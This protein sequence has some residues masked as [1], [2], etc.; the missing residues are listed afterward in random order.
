MTGGDNADGNI[1]RMVNLNTE[2]R[3]F[4][5]GKYRKSYWSSSLV[6][7]FFMLVFFQSTH[8]CRFEWMVTCWYFLQSDELKGAP[9]DF[10]KKKTVG[11]VYWLLDGWLVLDQIG[12]ETIS[13]SFGS[14]MATFDTEHLKII[15]YG[16]QK[17]SFQ[18]H[19][20]MK[21]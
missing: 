20:S 12:F 21:P 17:L 7:L 3:C 10:C 1:F 18:N 11:G 15:W 16:N 5:E 8:P 19:H 6:K 13:F 14:C 9:I 2:F 4:F